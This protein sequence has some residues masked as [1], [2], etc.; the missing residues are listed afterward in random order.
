MKVLILGAGLAGVTSAWFLAKDGHEVTVVE[1]HDGPAQETSFANGG[2]ISVSHPEPWANPGAPMQVLRWLGRK[3]APIRFP[4]RANFEQWQFGLRFLGQCLPGRTRRNMDAIA[5]LAVYSQ[6]KLRELR[7][8]T[9]IEYDSLQKGILHLYFDRAGLKHARKQLPLLEDYGIAAEMLDPEAC[10]ALEPALSQGAKN[11]RG[12]MYARND[13]S[14][15]ARKF[16]CNL[17][18]LC[19]QKGVQFY[20][21]TRVQSLAQFGDR[22]TGAYV[23]DDRGRR[24]LLSANA[25]VVAAGSF[26]PRLVQT[27]D[28]KL[29]IYPIKGYSLTVPLAPDVLAPQVS[30]TDEAHRIVISNLG[31]RLRIAGMAE[32]CGFDTSID[33]VRCAALRAQAMALLPQVVD[34]K[35]GE[36]WA[37]LRP[38][39]ASNV[40]IIGQSRLEGLY[41]NT[42][43]GTLGWTLS[44]GSASALTDIIAGRTP[45]PEFPFR[46]PKI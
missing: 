32:F 2:Q 1:R 21:R 3:N 23:V 30:I 19:A 43:H 38:G 5:H 18:V 4:L 40:P 10:L 17:A 46:L 12:A 11:L 35:S 20:Y 42:G 14:G 39:T 28:E 41:Y 29:P 25:V 22:I 36:F 24:G 16:T 31:D 37:G 9:G 15:D 44:C 33:K 13:E 26:S 34:A 45:E 6:A 27:L 7:E 8:E